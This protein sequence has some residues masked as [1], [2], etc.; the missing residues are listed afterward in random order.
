MQIDWDVPIAMD[1]GLVLRADVFRPVA[2]GKYPVLISYGP[3]GKGLHFEDGYKTAWDIMAR[4]YPDTV[5]NT[6]NR[7]QNWETADPEKWVPHGY[8]I[9]RVD[10]RGAGRS[11]GVIDHHSMRETR[12]FAACIEWAGTQAWSNG[13]V[14]LA[15]ISYSATNQGRV[16][17][18]APKHLAAMCIWE[19][20]ADRYRDSSHHGGILSTF[21]KHW[22][23]MQ[24]KTVQHGV[25]ER[26]KRSRVTGE[27]VCGPEILSEEELAA[28]IAPLWEELVGRALDDDYYQVRSAYWDK[29]KTPFLSCGNWGGNGLHLRGNVEGFVRAASKEKWLEMHGGSHWAIFYTDYANDLQR[30]FF[31]HYLKGE[32][33]G[34]EQQPRVQL[35]I[36]HPGEKFVIR[37]EHEWP[38]ART[39][40]T[41]MY[42]DP[43]GRALGAS[44]PSR[45]GSLAFEAKG[46]GLMFWTQP[47]EQETEITGPLAAKLFVSSST[48]DAD[49]FLVLRVFDPLG[50][51]VTFQGALDPHTPVA[52]GWLRA[53]HRKL[54][55]TLSLPYR[56]YHAHDEQQPL[57]P[58][59]VAELDVEIW[60]TSI[61]VPKGY[62]IALS[63]RGKDYEYDG[64]ATQL[65]N[66]K[67]PMRG[68]GPF[69]HDD[70]QDRPDSIF[71]GATTLHFGPDR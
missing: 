54:D 31:D 64:A 48:T 49:I 4:D 25:G 63:V 28:N 59:E 12:D 70:P 33:N 36:R 21:Q 46:D 23:A 37:H 17:G 7:H 60:P 38:I 2:P 14:G 32:K 55:P 51:E 1:D 27:L 65:S 18:L 30:R 62:R 20:Y 66:M 61:V 29:V 16:A 34:W 6:S 45:A 42:L 3:Y 40:W 35:N 53:S 43:V 41:K 69:V 71:A 9:V 56:P 58:G 26:G 8:A 19:G 50:K 15:G 5:A 67:N 24:V 13:K 47:L 57:T 11:P 52:Q 22:Q 44:A 68:C 39:Q 10:S